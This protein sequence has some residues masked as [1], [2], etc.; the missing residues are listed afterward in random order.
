MGD[1]IVLAERRRRREQQGE[2]AVAGGSMPVR[3]ATFLFD[4]ASPLTYLA[5]ERVERL[6]GSV[7]WQPVA[8]EA[9]HRGNPWVDPAARAVSRAG[10]NVELTARE[11][12]VLEFLVR[13]A[14][15]VV[16]RTQ[17]LDHVWDCNYE[18]STNLVDVYIGYLR[19]KLE[20]PFGRALIRTVRGVGYV[21]RDAA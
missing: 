3:S 6:L 8:A 4:L 21:L 10:V 17:L 12:A 20:E 16:S 18:G 14:G 5:A 11:F 2:T 13:Q 1:V 15:T 7:R 9:L 19:R